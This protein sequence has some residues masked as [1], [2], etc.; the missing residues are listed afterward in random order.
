ME[1]KHEE[2]LRFK[3]APTPEAVISFAREL[4]RTSPY[5]T[6]SYLGRS[7]RGRS[8]P[9]LNLGNREAKTGVL[10]VASHHASEWICT[11]ILLRFASEVCSL[12]SNNKCVYGVNAN[13]LLS[14]RYITLIPMLN[15]DGVAIQQN[16]VDASDPLRSRLIR[17]NGSEDFSKWQANGRGVD[18]NHNYDA[19]FDEYKALEASLGI[20]GGAAT[21]YSGE[22]PESEPETALLCNRVRYD[23]NTAAALTLHTQGEVI[24]YTSRGYAPR[25]S[26]S[27]AKVLSRM[28]GYELSSAE[29]TASYGGMT[30][31]FVT[32]L[33]KPCFT[34]ECGKG[35][36]PLPVSDGFGIYMKLREALFTFPILF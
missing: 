20:M 22:Y 18:L 21:K 15:P 34:L 12:A 35:E 32:K 17:M 6:L 26:E 3:R 13:T 11:S 16:G 10:Y 25:R 7:L 1:T 2:I 36:N 28:T 31:W 8:I 19:Y 29:G 14:S 33:D 27:A 9:I 4:D 30:D 23:D 24:Y 5:A